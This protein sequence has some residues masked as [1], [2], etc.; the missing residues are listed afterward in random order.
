MKLSISCFKTIYK[1][2]VSHRH[3]FHT[4]CTSVTLLC[5]LALWS[6]SWPK[7]VVTILITTIMDMDMDAVSVRAP[8]ALPPPAAAAVAAVTVLLP[9]PP[10][11]RS[12]NSS[13]NAD[14]SHPS[15]N[16]SASRITNHRLKSVSG[17]QSLSQFISSVLVTASSLR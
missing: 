14:P 13:V 17:N 2:G 5:L 7:E 3:R 15:P 16:Q 11:L 12:V 6:L 8:Q 9:L 1:S 10:R 4:K